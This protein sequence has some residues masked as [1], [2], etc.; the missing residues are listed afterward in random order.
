MIL[1]RGVYLATQYGRAKGDWMRT[2]ERKTAGWA[3]F[4]S[5]MLNLI[6]SCA[7]KPSPVVCP[8]GEQSPNATRECVLPEGSGPEG[9]DDS[10]AL[11]NLGTVNGRGFLV[12]S[13]FFW[14]EEAFSDQPMNFYISNQETMAPCNFNPQG[15]D[16]LSTGRYV[17]LRFQL[18]KAGANEFALGS[19]QAPLLNLQ[20]AD[21]EKAA[22]GQWQLRPLVLRFGTLKV[23]SYNEDAPMKL[24]LNSR[25][26]QGD[27]QIELNGAFLASRCQEKDLVFREPSDG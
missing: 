6:P 2:R 22:G 19:P 17:E 21:V 26:L 15:E 9:E 25:F 11:T 7:S 5:A 24:E 23:D 18:E 14:V 27:D 1:W 3:L 4:Y 10:I 12:Q 16:L 13:A 20:I 8:P